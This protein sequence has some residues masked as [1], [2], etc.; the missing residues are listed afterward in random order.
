LEIS[1][2][3]VQNLFDFQQLD[4]YSICAATGVGYRNI[5]YSTILVISFQLSQGLKDYNRCRETRPGARGDNVR[6]R[7]LTKREQGLG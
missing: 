3:A 7:V 6:D 1:V 4:N 5:T 2:G